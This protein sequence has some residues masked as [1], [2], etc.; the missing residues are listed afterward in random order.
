MHGLRKYGNQLFLCQFSFSLN[1]HIHMTKYKQ[2]EKLKA[3]FPGRS[4]PGRIDRPVPS[5]TIPNIMYIRR[6][7]L[8]YREK[9][10]FNESGKRPGAEK[11][12]G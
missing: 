1:Y 8:P 2:Q 11:S 5:C 6:N 9:E 3:V 12:Y 4:A 10:F 7:Y